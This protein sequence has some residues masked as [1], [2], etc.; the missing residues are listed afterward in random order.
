MEGGEEEVDREGDGESSSDFEG[1]LGNV[2]AL[3]DDPFQTGSLP[4][5]SRPRYHTEGADELCDSGIISSIEQLSIS[6]Y[7][8]EPNN[9]HFLTT[10]VSSPTL[11]SYQRHHNRDEN[12]RAHPHR[13]SQHVVQVSPCGLGGASLSPE[14]SPFD[15]NRSRSLPGH[16]RGQRPETLP[17]RTS[18]RAMDGLLYTVNLGVSAAFFYAAVSHFLNK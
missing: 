18:E 9:D 1:S 12:S 17:R 6:P 3:D 16:R 15:R 7:E 10:S 8:N 14:V 11:R 13:R 2:F 4:T 5:G